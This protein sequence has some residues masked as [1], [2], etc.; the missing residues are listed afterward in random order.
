[1]A[2]KLSREFLSEMIELYRSFQCLWKVKSHEYSNRNKKMRQKL[3]ERSKWKTLSSYD[4]P[5]AKKRRVDVSLSWG[6]IAFR[7]TVSCLLI[8]GVNSDNNSE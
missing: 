6:E 8:N 2:N 4:L 3:G 7:M 5:V 1:M